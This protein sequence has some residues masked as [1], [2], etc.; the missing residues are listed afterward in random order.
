MGLPFFFLLFLDPGSL[1]GG[2]LWSLLQK[3]AEYLP[4][5]S[6]LL[7]EELLLGIRVNCLA[8]PGTSHY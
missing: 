3:A 2:N 8:R 1:H 7:Q 4:L 5:G 6:V